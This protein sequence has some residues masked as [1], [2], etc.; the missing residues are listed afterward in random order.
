M[1]RFRFTEDEER[2]LRL[3]AETYRILAETV[4]PQLV[5]KVMRNLGKLEQM[6]Y[7]DGV[8]QGFAAAEL[9]VMMDDV[10]S[11]PQ[12][13]RLKAF[14]AH[15]AI[16][17]STDTPLVQVEEEHLANL[18]QTSDSVPWLDPAPMRYAPQTLA[19]WERGPE[20]ESTLAAQ[21]ARMKAENPLSVP[22]VEGDLP[23]PPSF[24]QAPVEADDDFSLPIR[25]AAPIEAPAFL[26]QVRDAI[27][28]SGESYAT[29][30]DMLFKLHLKMGVDAGYLDLALGSP[31]GLTVLA[32]CNLTHLHPGASINLQDVRAL[33]TSESD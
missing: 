3:M 22:F 11:M 30:T 5:S 17:G 8:R 9:A 21:V 4:P 25:I 33:G 12:A 23:A 24:R 20:P 27:M 15:A 16:Y 31:Q 13:R 2:Y 28:E 19:E 29:W 32:Q 6:S 14:Q 26:D 7:L 10:P 1:I 18:A